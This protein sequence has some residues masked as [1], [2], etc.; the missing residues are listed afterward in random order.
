[1]EKYNQMDIYQ[2]YLECFKKMTDAELICEFNR[3][4]TNNGW[5]GRKITCLGALQAEIG[6]RN[7]KSAD[8]FT[9][10]PQS[11]LSRLNPTSSEPP[12]NY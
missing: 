5:I 4:F 3:L 9:Q 2:E 12:S 1:M 8:K 10:T 6:K 7:I 11:R